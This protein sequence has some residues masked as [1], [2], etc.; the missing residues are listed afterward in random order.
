M[1]LLLTFFSFLLIN[2]CFSQGDTVA[3]M[4][5]KTPKTVSFVTKVDIRHAT[6]DG[7]YLN[8]YVVDI[9]YNKAKALHGKTIQVSGKVTIVKRV[10]NDHNGE[11]S[12]GRQVDTKHILHP[13]IKI[14][15]E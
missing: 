3:R 9:P 13:K 6:K 1:K 10:L 14:V 2:T 8:G 5:S 12:Q 15:S 4:Q 7:I 11:V